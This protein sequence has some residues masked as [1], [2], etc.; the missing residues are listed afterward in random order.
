MLPQPDP[1]VWGVKNNNRIVYIKNNICSPKGV[2][3]K[4]ISKKKEKEKR[5]EEKSFQFLN[6]HAARV[7]SE[8]NPPTLQNYVHKWNPEG[9]ENKICIR[10]KQTRTIG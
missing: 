8:G 10:E 2:F 1:K 5:K 6:K 9:K 3:R 7:Q 4:K